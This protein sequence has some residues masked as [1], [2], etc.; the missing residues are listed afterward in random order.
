MPRVRARALVAVCRAAVERP[1]DLE[2]LRAIP[3]IGDWTASYFALRALRDPDAFPTGDLGLRRALA[4]LGN[5]DPERWR[6]WRAY[7]AQHLW[8]IDARR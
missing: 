4:R 3:G 2:A 6:P 1:L 5:P 7:A 8:A